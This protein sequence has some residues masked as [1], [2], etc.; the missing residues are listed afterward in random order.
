MASHALTTARSRPRRAGVVTAVCLAVLGFVTVGFASAA[1]PDAGTGTVHACQNKA[2]GVLRLVDPALG[3]WTGRTAGCA[4]QRRT[5]GV[6]GRHR[7]ARTDGPG[8]G[9]QLRGRGAHQGSCP[10]VRAV[11]RVRAAEPDALGLEIDA[12]SFVVVGFPQSIVIRIAAPLDHDLV[13]TLTSDDPSSL[14]VPATTTI[15]AGE[16][17]G[18]FLVTPLA[19]PLL[20]FVDVTASAEGSTV[21]APIEIQQF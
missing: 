1:I 4:R 8:R 5:A 6:Q 11:V 19:R 14:V 16:I 7:A 9:A 10:V 21:Q 17:L 2:T 20:H 18:D 13:V 15:L 3:G 12:S